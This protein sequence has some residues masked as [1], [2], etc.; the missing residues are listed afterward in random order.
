MKRKQAKLII[1]LLFCL[2]ITRLQAQEAEM[3]AG[4]NAIGSNGSISYS[5]GQVAYLSVSNSSGSV[6]QGVQQPYEFFIVGVNETNDI[7]LELS[8][9]PNPTN[10]NVTL[11]SKNPIF[12]NRYYQ[13]F[14]SNGK[15]L[16][17]Q[18]L[19]E[20]ITLIPMES[21]PTST[22]ILKVSENDIE[23]KTFKIIK[24]Y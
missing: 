22:Y 19:T 3:T 6:N 5:L 10:S 7:S 23:V 20:K 24:N 18:K 12:D 9:Y 11:S 15:L 16:L 1:L 21:L 4:G 13:L 2:G 8:V 17:N 14:D